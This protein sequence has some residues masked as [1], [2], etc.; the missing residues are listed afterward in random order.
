M[1]RLH[2]LLRKYTLFL[3]QY[4]YLKI[5]FNSLMLPA[6]FSLKKVTAQMPVSNI[7]PGMEELLLQVCKII[8]KS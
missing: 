2:H 6:F 4:E 5:K 1:K 7:S 3:P 8:K